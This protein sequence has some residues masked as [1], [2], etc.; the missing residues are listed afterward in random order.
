MVDN[1]HKYRDI[2]ICTTPH[3][4]YLYVY[5]LSVSLINILPSYVN[6]ELLY[7]NRSTPTIT[8]HWTPYT[9]KLS[10]NWR[11]GEPLFNISLAK[12]GGDSSAILHD[13]NG[14]VYPGRLV[15]FQKKKF[16]KGRWI[17]VASV[18]VEYGK[19]TYFDNSSFSVPLQYDFLWDHLVLTIR[20]IQNIGW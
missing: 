2:Y 12:T 4:S 7:F 3:S 13:V 17:G 20:D 5:R 16:D 19:L 15:L 8:A 10:N 18:S 6:C 14:F 9:I 1:D 11:K